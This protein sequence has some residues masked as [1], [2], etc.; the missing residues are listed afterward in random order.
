MRTYWLVKPDEG[1]KSAASIS[2]DEGSDDEPS[3]YIPNLDRLGAMEEV[4]SKD[5]WGAAAVGVKNYNRL[6][7]WNVDVLY[8]L[9]TKVVS[10]RQVQTNKTDNVVIELDLRFGFA[11]LQAE[12]KKQ[13]VALAA[14]SGVVDLRVKSQLRA[15]VTLIASMYRDHS[16]H[17]FEHASHVMLSITKLMSRITSPPTEEFIVSNGLEGDPD[18][19][20]DKVDKLLHHYTFGIASEPLLQFA[21]AFAALIHDVDHPGVPNAQLVKEDIN[22]AKKYRQK[23]VAEKHSIRL[24][25]ERLMDSDYRE[26]RSCL[27]P[28]QSDLKRFR[29]FV[30]NTVMATDIADK[31]LSAKRKERWR[32]CFDEW[33]DEPTN[34]DVQRKATIVIEHLIQ[35][36]DVAHT[37]QHFEVYKK[38]NERLF[39]EVYSAFDNGRAQNDPSEKW[40]E[41]EI[42][43]FDFYIIP[44]A[45][46]LGACGVF[47]VASDEYLNYAQENRQKW[48]KEGKALVETWLSLYNAK[49]SGMTIDEKAN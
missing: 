44:L 6:V 26:L 18:L 32:H 15:Y 27:C 8:Q 24:A 28:N 20:E 39:F 35:A 42:G 37:M 45:K 46:K 1:A 3:E 14:K 2:E 40:Y 43:F 25:W 19:L 17:N 34:E 16:F 49:K 38:W 33:P 29:N 48:T 22:L 36:S 12:G 30:V 23:S 9:L 5:A 11:A 41:G 7:E 10:K 4:D 21:V 47:G 31:E 13:S